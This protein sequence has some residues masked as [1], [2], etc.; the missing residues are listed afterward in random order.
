[1]LNNYVIL[2]WVENA[3]APYCNG[4]SASLKAEWNKKNQS[5]YSRVASSFGSMG[6]SS[7]CMVPISD[8]SMIISWSERGLD[9]VLVL[10]YTIPPIE[11]RLEFFSMVIMRRSLL[12]TGIFCVFIVDGGIIDWIELVTFSFALLTSVPTIFP[13]SETPMIILPPLEFA[14]AQISWW[15]CFPADSLNSR[16]SDSPDSWLLFHFVGE[17]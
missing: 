15:I 17:Q 13:L 8:E 9:P 6:I 2:Y 14:K 4:R 7:Q 1:M 12:S 16:T 5:R 3:H 11:Q 10:I